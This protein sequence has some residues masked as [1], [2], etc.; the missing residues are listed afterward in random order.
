[1][2]G[3][4]IVFFGCSRIAEENQAAQA[5]VHDFPGFVLILSRLLKPQ[6]GWL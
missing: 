1:M 3:Q 2:L 4:E 5:A 6:L